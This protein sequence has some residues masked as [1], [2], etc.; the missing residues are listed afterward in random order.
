MRV[1]EILGRLDKVRRTG[2]RNWIACC[3][4]HDDKSPSM[5]VCDDVTGKVLVHCFGGCSAR[6]IVE[7]VGLNLA[8]LFADEPKKGQPTKRPFPAWDV[9]QCLGKES[10][11]AYM[12]ASAAARGEA[13]PKEDLDRCR[14]AASRIQAAVEVARGNG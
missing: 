13:I 1:E 6:E 10:M 4:A 7:A 14:L 8:D 11:I 12:V 2:E 5:S 9:L 3:P